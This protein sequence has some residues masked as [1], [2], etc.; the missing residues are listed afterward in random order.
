MNDAEYS[1]KL[2]KAKKLQKSIK[3]KLKGKEAGLSDSAKKFTEVNP[4]NVSDIDSY[5][6]KAEAVSKGLQ[7]TRKPS[8]GDLKVSKPFDIKK[9]DEYSKKETELEA[10]RNYN[11]AKESFQE[12]TGLEP[13]DLTLDQM[14][15]ML[16]EVDGKETNS[17]A[18]TEML[19]KKETHQNSRL[20][21]SERVRDKEIGEHPNISIQI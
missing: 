14:K 11:L 9:T 21:Y 18:D 3:T 6:E 19:K 4:S 5:L 2:D 16:Y 7:P 8:K 15:E 20:D 17:E 13:G 12:L 1:N 10:E